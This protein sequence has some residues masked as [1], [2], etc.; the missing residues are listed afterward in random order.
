VLEITDCGIRD[1]G[2]QLPWSFGVHS[3]TVAN[4]ENVGD[5][6]YMCGSIYDLKY[7]DCTSFDGEQF[8]PVPST[9]AGHH[10]GA[11]VTLNQQPTVLGG[12]GEFENTDVK[13][14]ETLDK[15]KHWIHMPDLPEPM[16]LFSAVT[17]LPQA[18]GNEEIWIFGGFSAMRNET[19]SASYWLESNTVEPWTKGPELLAAR[20]GHR[21]VIYN[22]SGIN[23]LLHIGGNDDS[24]SPMHIERWDFKRSTGQW[25]NYSSFEKKSN[26]KISLNMYTDYPEVFHVYSDFCNYTQF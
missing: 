5:R 8:Y 6:V 10:A 3:C 19:L 18:K 7:K 20:H 17:I 23:A 22:E 12:A 4:V 1:T 26:S 21:S 24:K 25:S 9:I 15:G 2:I 14:A 13:V 16:R 11:M